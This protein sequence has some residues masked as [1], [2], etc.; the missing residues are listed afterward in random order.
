D[1]AYNSSGVSFHE[2]YHKDNYPRLQRVKAAWDPRNFF[3]HPQ[4]VELPA[5]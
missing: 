5:G 1:P 4:S 3:R 2:L